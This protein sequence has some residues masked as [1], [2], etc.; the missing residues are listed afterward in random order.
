MCFLVFK[1]SFH[2][3]YSLIM[4]LM[5]QKMSFLSIAATSVLIKAAVVFAIIM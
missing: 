5:I 4:A 2:K 1:E 3:H